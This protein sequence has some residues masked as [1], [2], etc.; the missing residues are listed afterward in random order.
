[1]YNFTAYDLRHMSG[2]AS[3]NGLY[4]AATDA[5]E[6]AHMLAKEEV[7]NN[8]DLGYLH[9]YKAEPGTLEKQ[10]ATVRKVRKYTKS[11]NYELCMVNTF[12]FRFTITIWT[13]AV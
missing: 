6:M 7:E 9:N 10:L 2:E 12:C 8:V 5:M 4:D 3:S 13:P 11:I 1:M